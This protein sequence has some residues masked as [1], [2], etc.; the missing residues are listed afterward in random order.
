M[1]VKKSDRR[2]RQKQ[3]NR[4]VTK[5]PPSWLLPPPS[6]VTT[7]PRRAAAAGVAFPA[8]QYMVMPVW[9]P[10]EAS[11]GGTSM[12]VTLGPLQGSIGYYGSTPAPNTPTV[13]RTLLDYHGDHGW[14][15][16]HLLNDN[17]G[18]PGTARN[19]TPLTTAGNKNHLNTCE[20]LIKNTITA[21]FSRTLYNK[22]DPYWYGVY[23]KVEVGDQPHQ[24]WGTGHPWDKVAI[25]LTVWAHCVQM[26]KITGTITP[27]SV[28][29]TP[30]ACW[31]DPLVA[32]LV[33]NTGYS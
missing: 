2:D 15:A 20:T 9:G 21:C 28:L 25:S 13:M 31:F 3:R 26:D 4:L 22:V 7:R 23:Y 8:M 19:L 12:E 10:H 32:V 17:L 27:G 16:G 33:D 5:K 6:V 11:S 30:A 24:K 1:G 14:V 18:G 29:D